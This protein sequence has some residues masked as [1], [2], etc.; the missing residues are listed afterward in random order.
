MIT[1]VEEQP[2]PGDRAAQ[3]AGRP[4][5]VAYVMSRF[6]KL[7]ETFVL[8]EILAVQQLG[9]AVEIYPLL[10]P[11]TGRAALDGGSIWRKIW[12]LCR[13]RR[14]AGTVHPEAAAL[15]RRA[16]YQ[17]FV[18]AAIVRA[19][20]HYLWHKPR[21]YAAALGLVLK[22][23]WRSANKLI[24]SL[25]IF[26][27]TVYFARQMDVAGIT[28]IHAH[29]ANH[30]ATAALLIHRLAGIPFSF[31]AHGSDLHRNR[32]LLRE[33]AAA[34]QFV[35]TIS[36]YNRQVILAHCGAAVQRKLAVIHCGVD[37]QVF[38]P[39]AGASSDPAG[40][41]SRALRILSIGTLHE[42][43]GHRYLI[44]AC[45]QLRQ[46]GVNFVCHIIG[47]G[48]DRQPLQ[49]QILRGGLA[50]HVHLL[51]PRTRAEIVSRVQQADVLAAPSVFS[52][53]GRR[54]GI[55]VV[56][57][58]AMACGLPV[59]ASAISGIPELVGD[60]QTGTLVPPG[61]AHALADA[62]Q[63]LAQDAAL[64]RRLGTAG[65]RRVE[66]DFNLHRNARQLVRAFG[67]PRAGPPPGTTPNLVA[68][69]PATPHGK[70][71]TTAQ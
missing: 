33:K 24:G 14:P 57:M 10:G 56:L 69:A 16:H 65:R 36:Q 7:T 31:T 47:D 26:P 39:A 66:A 11:D 17:P 41:P 5:R 2:R 51:G 42:V 18:S 54:E 20:L 27:K 25:A 12:E 9:V 3:Q 62:L 22:H 61:D 23:T 29:F 67:S 19:Q 44:E 37:T 68:C 70:G 6:P 59:V 40:Q 30:P 45:A 50:D 64:R 28:H 1:R 52:Q 35:V 71:R 63:N 8:Y 46:R 55:P 53:S 58:E 38:R 49:D 32:C 15:A 60:G 48:P 43:K 13:G 21:A 34:A 4:I